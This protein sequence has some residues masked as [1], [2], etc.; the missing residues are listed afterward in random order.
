MCLFVFI[1]VHSRLDVLSCYFLLFARRHVLQRVCAF[2]DFVV[3]DDED[4]AGVQLVGQFH[5]LFQFG[6]GA[7]FNLTAVAAQFLGQD[8]SVAQGGFAQRRDKEVGAGSGWLDR[9]SVV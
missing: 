9:K 6:V 3:S 8:S 7:D 1:R 5:G 2:R 4:V